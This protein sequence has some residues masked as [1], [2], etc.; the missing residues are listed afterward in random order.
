MQ[1][2]AAGELVVAEAE[3]MGEEAE[4]VLVESMNQLYKSYKAR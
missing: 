2:V 3:V 4:D 1:A